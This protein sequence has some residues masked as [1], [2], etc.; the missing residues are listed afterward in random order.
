MTTE[1]LTGLRGSIQSAF[2]DWQESSVLDEPRI[3]VSDAV[4]HAVLEHTPDFDGLLDAIRTG[5][6][7]WIDTP[8]QDFV[9]VVYWAIFRAWQRGSNRPIRR[10]SGH[11]PYSNQLV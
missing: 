10:T 7:E 11:L 8:G 6:A 5:I 1:Q 2:Q 9:E 4:Y 3:Y